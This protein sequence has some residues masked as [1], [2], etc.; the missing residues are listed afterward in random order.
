MELAVEKNEELEIAG[1]QVRSSEFLQTSG[2]A[3]P[4]NREDRKLEICDCMID[5]VSAMFNVSSKELRK[6]GRAS[7][8]VTRVRQ[9]AM[10]I[11]HCICGLTMTD[12]GKGFGRDRTTVMYACHMVEDMRD[13]CEF[14]RIITKVERIAT[15]AFRLKAE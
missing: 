4:V 12:V 5:I 9:I 2:R 13:N 14:D 1:D 8:P 10:Y 15:A 7:V 6:P 3:L 11:C